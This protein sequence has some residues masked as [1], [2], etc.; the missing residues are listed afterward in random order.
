MRSLG[1]AAS[2][3]LCLVLWAPPAPAGDETQKKAAPAAAEAAETKAPPPPAAT[4]VGDD[5]VCAACH[6]AQATAV[7]KSPHAAAGGKGAAP[8]GC[9]GCHGA[10][11][12]HVDAGGGKGVGGLVT[13]AASEPVAERTAPCLRCHAG[14][15]DLHDYKGGEH[16]LAGVACTDCHGGHQ[17]VGDALLRKATPAVCYG[18]HGEVRAL[19][20]LTEH[21]KVDQGVVSCIDCHQPHGTRNVGMLKAANDRT[22]YKC[23]GDL[24][25]PFVF[26][27]VGLVTEGCQRCHVPHGGVNRHL[28]IRQQ[29]AQLCYECHTVT[30][31]SH[32]QPSY[33][34]C[35]RCHVSIHGSNSNA[36]FLQQ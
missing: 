10:G 30:P 16:A 2:I 4:Y 22:C 20:A 8:W 3:A 29:V 13:F 31:V 1:T 23:H 9:E 6:E 27:H 15:R 11:Q 19:F 21:H 14:D 5:E 18:C 36:M 24:E 17:G 12:A 26:E 32:T 25:G 7:K 28:L 35:T 33:R 34:D